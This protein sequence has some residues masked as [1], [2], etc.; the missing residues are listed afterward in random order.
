[1]EEALY[2]EKIKGIKIEYARSTPFTLAV[3]GE[4]ISYI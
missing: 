2:M 3:C 1:M 4:T